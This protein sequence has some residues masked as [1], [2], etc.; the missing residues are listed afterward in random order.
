MAEPWHMGLNGEK[1]DGVTEEY[2]KNVVTTD[3][4]LGLQNGA[5]KP[6]SCF[7]RESWVMKEIRRKKETE[8]AQQLSDSAV[9]A[10]QKRLRGSMTRHCKIV[11]W[12]ELREISVQAAICM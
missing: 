12:W 1:L 3:I 8:A 6:S 2:F 11:T 9:M 4:Q 10:V 5:A 7:G